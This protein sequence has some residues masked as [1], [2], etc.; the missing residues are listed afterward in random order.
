M[1][2]ALK[3]PLENLSPEIFLRVARA[4]WHERFKSESRVK[5]TAEQLTE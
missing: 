4:Q 2:M 3:I 1:S 5:S